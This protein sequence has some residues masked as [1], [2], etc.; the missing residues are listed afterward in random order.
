LRFVVDECCHRLIASALRE[1]GH[2]VAY[3]AESDRQATDETIA[4]LAI[5]ED[6]IVDTAD[7]DFGELAIRHR[8]PMPGVL[9]LAPTSQPIDRRVERLALLVAE[10]GEQL[11]GALTI[12]EDERLRSRPLR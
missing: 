5:E 8:F 9:L 6:R 4:P 2:G 11:R 10:L 12:V 7:Y 3:V 1:A